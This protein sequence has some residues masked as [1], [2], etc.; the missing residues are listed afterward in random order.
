[1]QL[2][3]TG[4]LASRLWNK[5]ALSIIGMDVPAVAQSSDTLLPAARARFGLSLAPGTNTSEAMEAVRR[6]MEAHTPFR[7][8]VR[9]IP[10]SRTDYRRRRAAGDWHAAASA[11]SSVAWRFLTNG[12][13]R[14]AVNQVR[15]GFEEKCYS[16]SG[17]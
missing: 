11:T 9:F 3:G 14:S 10:G 16:W 17:V 6:H 13:N 15:V 12:R 4:T 5:P 7:A 1:M 2:A 8:D